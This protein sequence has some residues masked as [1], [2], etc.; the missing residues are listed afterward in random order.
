MFFYFMLYFK[1]KH[2]IIDVASSQT[3][4]SRLLVI[5]TNRQTDT[6]QNTLLCK[7]M[8]CLWPKY[9]NS[10]LFIRWKHAG[11]LSAEN[12]SHKMNA[13]ALSFTRTRA[14]TRLERLWCP[15][16]CMHLG[17]CPLSRPS[18]LSYLLPL[19][20]QLCSILLVVFHPHAKAETN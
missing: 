4:D 9:T 16:C 10:Q 17:V 13:Y 6:A 3:A 18:A 19:Y 5:H 11:T 7:R 2:N 8:I 20:P 15:V 1:K 12:L 14:H